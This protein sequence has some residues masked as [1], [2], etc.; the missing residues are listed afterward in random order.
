MSEPIVKF[1]PNGKAPIVSYDVPDKTAYDGRNG[2]ELKLPPLNPQDPAAPHE[3]FNAAASTP[4]PQRQSF[5][6]QP[7]STVEQQVRAALQTGVYDR[8]FFP[9]IVIR[10]N[11]LRVLASTSVFGS[12]SN[13]VQEAVSASANNIPAPPLRSLI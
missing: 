1:D 6:G 12:E 13:E 11:S 4:P 2:I 9:N 3:Y 7:V 10:T 5:L 8:R